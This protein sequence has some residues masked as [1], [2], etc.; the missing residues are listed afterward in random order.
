MA[1]EILGLVS[2]PCAACTLKLRVYVIEGEYSN[3]IEN[4]AIESCNVKGKMLLTNHQIVK[5]SNTKES[6]NTMILKCF[7]KRT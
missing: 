4:I 2:E 6:D 7:I 3:C 5:Q 1:P